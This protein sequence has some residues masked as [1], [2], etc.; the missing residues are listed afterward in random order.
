MTPEGIAQAREVIGERFGPA[1]VPS[2]P[3]YYKTKA[4][5]AQE[6][7]EAIRPTNIAR[8]PETLRLDG[9]LQRLYEL[10]W[11]RMVA[12]QMEQ[13]RLDR[14]TVDIETP[15]G[16]TGLRATG[17]VVAFDGFIAVYEEG[18]DERVK[19]AEDEDDDG[20]RLPALKEGAAA[21]PLARRA[22]V[23][24]EGLRAPCVFEGV[25]PRG[26]RVP[27]GGGRTRGACA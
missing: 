8:A 1:Y 13:A 4:K 24:A 21:K 5:N 15:D 16:L 17:Q 9:D 25:R 2:E 10:I 14:T 3:R 23:V 11:K 26:A 22:E 20:G 18:R 19:G 12:S 7:H 6:A 27:C